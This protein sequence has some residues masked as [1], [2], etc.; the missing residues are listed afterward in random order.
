MV[1]GSHYIQVHVLVQLRDLSE[2]DFKGNTVIGEPVVF[3]KSL[4]IPLPPLKIKT[5]ICSFLD[6]A[7]VV[8]SI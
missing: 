4:T 7:A 5:S 3:C 2:F 6:Q 1:C 8:I